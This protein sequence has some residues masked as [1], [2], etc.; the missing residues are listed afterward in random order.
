MLFRIV[1]YLFCKQRLKL[2]N[3]VLLLSRLMSNWWTYLNIVK[4][5]IS[6]NNRKWKQCSLHNDTLRGYVTIPVRENIINLK[7]LL[8]VLSCHFCVIQAVQRE[9]LTG[10]LCWRPYG[11]L[12]SARASWLSTGT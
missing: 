4:K 9:L 1:C 10:R 7:R 11:K 2:L 12:L 6:T 5:A 8:K 3:K